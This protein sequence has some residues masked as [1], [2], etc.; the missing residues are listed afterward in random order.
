[1]NRRYFRIAF[2]LPA[3]ALLITPASAGRRVFQTGTVKWFMREKGFGF[4]TMDG[5]G[6]DIFVHSSRVLF[7]RKELAPYQR[8]TFDVINGTKGPEAVNVLPE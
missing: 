4:I 7:P 5:S 3:L 1:M 2:A 6:K 8:V